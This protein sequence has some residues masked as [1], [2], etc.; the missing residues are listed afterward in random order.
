MDTHDAVLA[1]IEGW[2]KSWPAADADG[3]ARLYATDAVFRSLP[4]RDP[5]L[6]REGAKEYAAWSFETQES[7]ECW[8]GE[9]IVDGA[10]ASVE[11]WAVVTEKDGTVTTIVGTSMLRFDSDGL[12]CEQRDTWVTEEGRHEPYDGWSR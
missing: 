12:C 9:P 1:W 2:A 3:V 4:F 8:F 5:H 11:Y 7:A 10:R 6:G